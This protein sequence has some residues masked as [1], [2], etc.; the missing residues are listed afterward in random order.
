MSIKKLFMVFCFLS[1]LGLIVSCSK[2]VDGI[3]LDNKTSYTVEYT[4]YDKDNVVAGPVA[5]G[6]VAANSKKT[7]DLNGCYLLGARPTGNQDALNVYPC[8][9]S[10]VTFTVSGNAFNAHVD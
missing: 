3:A 10:T 9:G 8:G 4:F 6:S 5:T 2:D 7:L 1:V